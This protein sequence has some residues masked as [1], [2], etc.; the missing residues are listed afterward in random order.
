M[1]LLY[2]D[3]DNKSTRSTGVHEISSIRELSFE[4]CRGDCRSTN[5]T[6]SVFKHDTAFQQRRQQ[7]ALWSC[8]VVTNYR[9]QIDDV[10]IRARTSH[11]WGS[12]ILA[13]NKSNNRCDEQNQT[14][15]YIATIQQSPKTQAH[16]PTMNGN[17]MQQNK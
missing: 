11:A 10:T 3:R 14:I 1:A 15:P 8:T 16:K 12:P 17:S 2:P 13:C 4:T 7:R 6:P 5:F 9:H